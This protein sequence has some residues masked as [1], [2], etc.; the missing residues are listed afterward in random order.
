[1]NAR[2]HLCLVEDDVLL[3]DLWVRQVQRSADFLCGGSFASAEVALPALV[4]D[5]PQVL[6]ADWKLPGRD[7]LELIR[8]FKTVHPDRLAVL[9]TGYD[10]VELPRLALLAGVDGCLL[11]R[12]CPDNPLPALRRVLAGECTFSTWLL[13][14]LGEHLRAEA[15]LAVQRN[16]FRARLSIREGAVLERLCRGLTAKAVAAE[17]NLSVHTV[18]THCREIRRK[19]EASNMTEAVDK[20]HRLGPPSA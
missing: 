9:L 5:P 18:D 13:R 7:G 11:K 14:R 20:W 6:L 19:L 1:M 17:L 12:E 2:A 4:A 16:E 15:L 10:E 8:E 3:R